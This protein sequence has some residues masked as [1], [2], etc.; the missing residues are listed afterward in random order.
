MAAYIVAT[1]KITDPE[2]F[3]LYGQGIAGLSEKY[4]GEPLVRGA[5]KEMLEGEGETGD[6]V[7]VSRFPDADAVR[8]YIHSAEY[9]AAKLL[10]L[11]AATIVMRLVED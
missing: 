5:V 4:G 7:V 10:R 3:K 1:V 9:Q 6:R 11:G 2:K 8:A